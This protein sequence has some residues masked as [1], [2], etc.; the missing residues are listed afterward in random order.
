MLSR[1][2]VVAVLVKGEDAVRVD[3]VGSPAPR[4]G[5]GPGDAAACTPGLALGIG[6]GNGVQRRLLLP[7]A[8]ASATV[9]AAAGLC[10]TK[11][12]G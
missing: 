11:G 2:L 12:L 4:R 7:A 5:L 10:L 6:L 1:G 3:G 8:G 9:I